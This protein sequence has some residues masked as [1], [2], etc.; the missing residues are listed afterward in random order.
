MNNFERKKFKKT[1]WAIVENS[2]PK[3]KGTLENYLH[4]IR[5]RINPM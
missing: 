4:K 2:P 3:E 1:Y 5:N